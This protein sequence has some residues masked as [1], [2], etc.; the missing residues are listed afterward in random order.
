MALRDRPCLRLEI[1]IIAY[2]VTC[3]IAN[4]IVHWM[5]IGYLP[6]HHW[7]LHGVHMHHFGLGIFVAMFAMTLNASSKDGKVHGFAAALSGC[8]LALIFDE[9]GMWLNLQDTDIWHWFGI[10]LLLSI[11]V[12]IW[13]IKQLHLHAIK[14]ISKKIT[15]PQ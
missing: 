4:L 12:G 8:A 11:L 5:S 13:L 7:R 14:R 10:I 6:K 2:T 3:G 15:P 1:M 9:Y